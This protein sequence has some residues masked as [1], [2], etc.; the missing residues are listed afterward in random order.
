M[1]AV[2]QRVTSAS[3]RIYQSPNEPENPPVERRIEIGFAVLLGVA[4]GDTTVEADRMV[5]KMIGLR[6]FADEHEKMNRDIRQVGGAFLVVSQFTLLADT[7]KGRRPSFTRAADPSTGK[8]LYLYVVRRLGELGFT[9]ATGE[10][11]AHMEVEI[12]N[13]GPV[14]ILLDTDDM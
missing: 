14:T 9:V 10:F 3:V 11:G 12:V 7:R 4:A 5:D 1:K 2:L 13:D 8:S 6:V